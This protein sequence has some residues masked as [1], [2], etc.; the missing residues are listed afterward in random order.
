MRG[1]PG[2]IRQTRLT[3]DL[4]RYGDEGWW[5]EQHPE[6]GVGGVTNGWLHSAFASLDELW[7]EGALEAVRTPLLILL[8]SGEGLVDNAATLRAATRLPDATVE[9]FA[10]AGHE[11]V[12]EIDAIRLPVLDRI[13][14]FLA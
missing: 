6:L 14:A 1:A 12:R 3:H 13:A 8:A 4:D 9:T 7:A 10:G 2:S 11:L 5:L